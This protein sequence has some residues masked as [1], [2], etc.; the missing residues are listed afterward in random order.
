MKVVIDNNCN[1][2]SKYP[3]VGKYTCSQ[4][5]SI[6]VLFTAP[7]EGVCLY[8]EFYQGDRSRVGVK[9]TSW[10]EGSYVP[11]CITLDSK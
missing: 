9:K 5:E 6:V 3:Y 4:G 11:T 2:K 8:D 10:T 7:K 1:E